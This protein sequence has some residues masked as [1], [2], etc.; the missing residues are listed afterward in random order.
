MLRTLLLLHTKKIEI[1]CHK[2]HLWKPK[3]LLVNKVTM[4]SFF[5][6]LQDLLFFKQVVFPRLWKAPKL[7][8][9][10][11]NH[12][13]KWS[14]FRWR[15]P[16]HPWK[17]NKKSLVFGTGPF[18]LKITSLLKKERTQF[19]KIYLINWMIHKVMIILP[20]TFENH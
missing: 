10:C 7:M 19:K 14:F 17:I 15:S 3:Q 18:L 11:P 2:Y 13:P 6:H 9:G 1:I 5:R 8:P 4:D 16:C 12:R 20:W